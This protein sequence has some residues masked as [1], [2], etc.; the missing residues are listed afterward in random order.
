[1]VDLETTKAPLFFHV[2]Q[3]ALPEGV[4]MTVKPHDEIDEEQ[5]YLPDLELTQLKN[6]LD[7]LGGPTVSKTRR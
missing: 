3:A 7:A 6:E 2:I 4:K 1:M 5:R